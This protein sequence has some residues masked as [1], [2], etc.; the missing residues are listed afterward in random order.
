MRWYNMPVRFI[1]YL[2]G[3]LLISCGEVAAGANPDSLKSSEKKQKMY[4]IGAYPVIFYTDETRL[5]GGAAAQVV[6]GGQSERYS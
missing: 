4:S 6:H 1:A 2:L 5:A 3:I